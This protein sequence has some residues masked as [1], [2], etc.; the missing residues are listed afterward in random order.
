[1]NLGVA[2]LAEHVRS[3]CFDDIVDATTENP[4]MNIRHAF[5]YKCRVFI[6]TKPTTN[7]IAAILRRSVESQILKSPQ[8]LD[9]DFLQYIASF[10]DG[11][12]RIA[13]NIVEIAADL[14]RRPD[15]TRE[16]EAFIDQELTL[17]PFR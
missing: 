2:R 5:V 11:D 10:A 9:D 16:V 17:R 1:M 4:S 6:V 15:M 7:D 8:L 13:L 12:G 3:Q 14:C